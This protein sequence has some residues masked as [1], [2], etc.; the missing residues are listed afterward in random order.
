MR[1]ASCNHLEVVQFLL[2]HGAA[3]ADQVNTNGE[4]IAYI[5]VESDC[6]RIVQYVTEIEPRLVSCATTSPSGVTVLMAAA[7]NGSLKSTKY[8]LDKFPSDELIATA[9]DGRS[10]LHFAAASGSKK[11]VEAVLKDHPNVNIKSRDG[12]TALHYAVDD[13]C[14]DPGVISALLRAGLDGAPKNDMGDLPAHYASV[15]GDWDHFSVLK[16]LLE[17]AGDEC[18][19]LNEEN[20]ACRSALQ[21][22]TSHSN[23]TDY[24]LKMINTLCN[25]RGLALE[26]PG[27]GLTGGIPLLNLVWKLSQRTV[28]KP[29][30]SGLPG[31][32]IDAWR[33]CEA[34]KLLVRRG[35]A[36]DC[37]DP[38]GNTA[39]HLLC[40]GNLNFAVCDTVEFLLQSSAPIE[41]INKDG[42]SVMDALFSRLNKGPVSPDMQ[43]YTQRILSLLIDHAS[44]DQLDNYRLDGMQL[45]NLCIQIGNSS[46]IRKVLERGAKVDR[47]DKSPSRDPGL[48][49]LRA[50]CIYKT[51][52]GVADEILDKCSDLNCLDDAGIT[53]LVLACRFGRLE[54]ARSL[55][56]KG[57]DRPTTVQ[58]VR[59]I[60]DAAY[61]GHTDIVQFLIELG[62]DIN[63]TYGDRRMTPLMHAVERGNLRTMKLLL[64]NGADVSIKAVR[65]WTLAHYLAS[66]EDLSLLHEML[67]W[68]LT[69]DETASVITQQGK[70]VG[71]VTPLHLAAEKGFTGMITFLLDNKFIPHVNR[72]NDLRTTPLHVAVRVG[73]CHTAKQLLEAGA[74]VNAKDAEGFS[75]VHIA[76]SHSGGSR[77]SLIILRD[78]LE[79]GKYEHIAL[80]HTGQTALHVA[81][82]LGTKDMISL[83]LETP[84]NVNA[85]DHSWLTPLHYAIVRGDPEIIKILEAAGAKHVAPDSSAA[86]LDGEAFHDKEVVEPPPVFGANSLLLAAIKQRDLNLCKRACEEGADLSFKFSE[87]KEGKCTPL[88]CAI[89][90][91]KNTGNGFFYHTTAIAEF[92][93]DQDID[94]N[95][96]SC[97]S[98]MLPT[99]L[100]A[101]RGSDAVIRKLLARGAKTKVRTLE[102]L[103]LAVIHGSIVAINVLLEHEESIEG[104]SKQ[105]ILNSQVSSEDAVAF[106][107]Y[108]EFAECK[109]LQEPYCGSAMH[110][111]AYMGY[112]DV[113]EFLI[114]EGAEIDSLNHFNHTPLMHAIWTDALKSIQVLLDAGASISHRDAF[115]RTPAYFALGNKNT[116]ALRALQKRGADFSEGEYPNTWTTETYLS[117]AL[118][119][120]S[121]PVVDFLLKLGHDPNRRSG[122]YA[123]TPLQVV[124]QTTDA[125]KVEAFVA[126]HAPAYDENGERYG[127]LLAAACSQSSPSLVKKLLEKARKNGRDMV[128]Y[129]NAGCYVYATPLY[130]AAFRGN[131]ELLMMLIEEGA[132][133]KS[134]EGG[135]SG[136]PLDAACAI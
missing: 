34:I 59:A 55:I 110:I 74:D 66:R 29:A 85:K 89:D 20:G 118:F 51:S 97:I 111:A 7:E 14:L 105:R 119:L 120:E 10:T 37:K 75:P 125:V 38:K 58:G 123:H 92:L 135:W 100:A 77:F 27:L 4:T 50:I 44:D 106:K 57:A 81:V 96:P 31:P 113:L 104:G 26:P 15:R 71:G 18:Q 102:A 23:F 49:P 39:L 136:T 86:S 72:A 42:L 95:A 88:L 69:W 21:I 24:S 33:L 127:T 19:W 129:V 35:A 63:S 128:E 109:L 101:G 61:K 103:H 40:F 1:A 62:V 80:T 36:V 76:A 121:W 90:G 22:I 133:V 5:A 16:K 30:V 132:D 82:R 114:K 112:D 28:Y 73:N 54:V 43:I 117:Q 6:H 99:H 3:L 52:D 78:L 84:E 70:N 79:T 47:P 45:L 9:K 41:S 98:D 126:E 94:I 124:L 93:A 83:L 116:M 56:A 67:P 48:S 122:L 17:G 2:Q 11:V 46:I 53:L 115:G 65:Q 12:C 32:P 107:E 25:Y 64:E 131:M 60:A 87:C 68:N 108:P 8:I 13:D 91:H 134:K 130:S